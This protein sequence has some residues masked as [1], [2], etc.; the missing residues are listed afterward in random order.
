MKTKWRS[1]LF[2]TLEVKPT[3]APQVIASCAFLHNV[4]LDNG[5][6]LEPDDDISM[7]HY[8]IQPPCEAMAFNETSGNATRDRLA[9]LVSG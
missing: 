3:I 1:T 8:D 6:M 7:E 2:R 5:D 4:C 9:G